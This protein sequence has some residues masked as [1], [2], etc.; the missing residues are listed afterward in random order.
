MSALRDCVLVSRMVPAMDTIGQSLS[1]MLI[2]T[3]LD[4]K[5][6]FFPGLSGVIICFTFHFQWSGDENTY[7]LTSHYLVRH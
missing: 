5:K 2:V 7:V 3:R 4:L 6:I 1:S